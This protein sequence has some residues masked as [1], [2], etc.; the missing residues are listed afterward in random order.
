MYLHLAYKGLSLVN[1]AF[2]ASI[3][4]WQIKDSRYLSQAM[5]SETMH[6]LLQSP[7]QHSHT[8]G[9]PFTEQKRKPGK[10]RKL[11]PSDA[12]ELAGPGPVRL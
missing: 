3:I 9:L 6:R 12:L 7:W 2:Y 10:V 4:G 8:Y 5:L 1:K 11:I